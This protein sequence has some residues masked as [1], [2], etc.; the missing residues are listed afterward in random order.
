MSL[1]AA[2]ARQV[3]SEVVVNM[4][5]MSGDAARPE[6]DLAVFDE[7]T[8]DA[9]ADGDRQD[10]AVGLAGAER[11]LAQ[12]V[13]VH[14][15]EDAHLQAGC[16]LKQSAQGCASPTGHRARGG[17]DIAGRRVD[18]AGASDGDTRNLRVRSDQG[19][20]KVADASRHVRSAAHRV[21][22][23][24]STLGDLVGVTGLDDAPP[25]LGATDVEG[26]ERS[27]EDPYEKSGV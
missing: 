22:G 13:R 17:D 25:D 26:K 12:T 7:G 3:G 19:R 24:R 23:N 14:V 4:A 1:A 15:V 5:H 11:G 20:G 6:G 27:H 10:G 9:G 21:G 18:D 2:R 8:T 16:L